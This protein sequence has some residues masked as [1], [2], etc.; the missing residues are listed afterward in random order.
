MSI[1][2]FGKASSGAPAVSFFPRFNLGTSGVLRGADSADGGDE[3]AI[4][5]S[6]R[7]KLSD[8]TVALE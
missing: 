4:C 3:P 6:P 8:Q 2:G 5:N 7:T 1:Y